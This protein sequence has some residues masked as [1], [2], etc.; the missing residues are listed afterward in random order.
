MMSVLEFYKK[1]DVM[2]NEFTNT[3]FQGR[4]MY[5]DPDVDEAN[6]LDRGDLLSLIRGQE[7]STPEFRDSNPFCCYRTLHAWVPFDVVLN[8]YNR[9]EDADKKELKR[10]A[11]EK[12]SKVDPDLALDSLQSVLRIQVLANALRHK[13]VHFVGMLA[14]QSL[15]DIKMPALIVN[16]DLA[17]EF[18][19]KKKTSEGNLLH[20]FHNHVARCP[21]NY[22]P[23]KAKHSFM[24]RR[25][26]SGAAEDASKRPRRVYLSEKRRAAQVQFIKKSVKAILADLGSTFK[27]IPVSKFDSKNYLESSNITFSG[28]PEQA[29]KKIDGQSTFVAVKGLNTPVSA[30][31]AA[32]LDAVHYELASGM[33]KGRR[34]ENGVL[35]VKESRYQGGQYLPKADYNGWSAKPQGDQQHSTTEPQLDHALPEADLVRKAF[36]DVRILLVDG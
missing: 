15:T 6:A 23:K 35:T 5:A 29:V 21:E 28:W 31:D 8:D 22:T 2:V 1:F 9:L 14:F 10:L 27:D 24:K 19:E 30:W 11:L 36:R 7:F 12:A 25:A 3:T 13:S 26:Q 20:E 33:I 18:F 32:T 4:P 17:D 34:N 16:S